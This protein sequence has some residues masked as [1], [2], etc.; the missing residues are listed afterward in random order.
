MFYYN[1]FL[2]Y[3]ARNKIFDKSCYAINKQMSFEI[4]WTKKSAAVH[5][6]LKYFIFSSESSDFTRARKE[7]II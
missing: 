7:W 4:N 6:D 2:S 3:N 5:A 1:D